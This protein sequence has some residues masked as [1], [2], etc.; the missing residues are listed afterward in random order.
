MKIKKLIIGF[1]LTAG[2]LA[3]VFYVYKFGLPIVS[4]RNALEL[5]SSEAILIFETTEP[6]MAWNQ[7][8]T[9]PIWERLSELPVLYQAQSQIMALDSILGKSGRLEKALKGNQFVISLHP[10]GREEF[11]FLHTIAFQDRAV[12]ELLGELENNLPPLT[13][14]NTRN[15]SNVEIKELQSLDLERNL[16]FALIGNIFVASYSSFL[17]EEAIRYAQNTNLSDFKSSNRPLFDALPKSRGLGVFRLSSTGLGRLIAGITRDKDLKMIQSFANRGVSANLELK[18]LDEKISM[19]GKAFFPDGKK[20]SFAS[21]SGT[22][23]KVFQNLLSNRVS[24][25]HQYT[26]QDLKQLKVFEDDTFEITSTLKGDLE[27]ELIENGFFEKLSGELAFI[28]FELIPNEP[29]DKI[30]LAKTSDV[31]AQINMLKSF[32]L[33]HGRSETGDL[34]S[35]FYQQQEIFMIAADEFPAHLFGGKFQGFSDTYFTAIGDVLVMSNSSKSMKLFIDDLNNDNTWGKSLNQKRMLDIISPD[36]GYHFMINT[37]RFWAAVLEKSSPNW[38]PFFQKY[39]P[40]IKSMDLMSIKV[41]EYDKS[42]Q[43]NL[44]WSY[45]LAPIKAVQDVLLTE[46]RYVQFQ[47]RLSYGPVMVQNFVDRSQEFVLQ[48]IENNLYLFTAEGE[49]VF[50]YPLDGPI[51]SDIFQVDFYKNG[52]LQLLFATGN[53]IY[54][55]DRLGNLLPNYPLALEGETI[56]HLN[57][58]DYSNTRDYRFFLGTTTGKLILLDKNGTALEGWNPNQIRGPLAVKPAHHRI[59]GVGDRMVALSANGELYFFNRRGE[60]EPG[61]PIRLGDGLSTEYILLERGSAR[62]SRLVTITKEGEVVQV[63]LRGELAY[64]NQLLRPDRESRFH[65]IKDQKEDRYLFVVY[66]YNKVTVLSNEF[67]PLFTVDIFSQELKFQ[68]FSFGTDKNIFVITDKNQEFIYLYNL[69][70]VLLNTL[71]IS[72]D[73]NVIIRYSGS[74]NDYTIFTA[75]GNRFSEYRLPL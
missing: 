63:N 22:D 58:V 53:Q 41:K 39:A 21:S 40:Q 15:Y 35:D 33:N 49:Q 19:D 20:F 26:L 38:Q 67:K 50:G 4:K 70:G 10:V 23:A 3:A 6:V 30:L 44:E 68:F 16:S 37:P 48:D 65:L 25:L 14:I 9:Q 43:L 61:S 52:K 74:Q 5:V 69:E 45:N 28:L 71:P 42:N 54:I 55:I 75:S 62:D 8:V 17:V 36:H 66:E 59:A 32:A 12:P 34:P 29:Q 13:R 11:D 27:K 51:I 60:V 73:S 47:N 31:E 57:L 64:R 2:I 46:N 72:G 24:V 18:F 1:L 7:L 56:T